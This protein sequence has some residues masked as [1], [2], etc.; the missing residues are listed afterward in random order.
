[1]CSL[2]TFL[3]TSFKSGSFCW[4]VSPKLL[5]NII[6]KSYIRSVVS[7]FLHIHYG[8]LPE[9]VLCL[10]SSYTEDRMEEELTEPLQYA[11]QLPVAQIIHQVCFPLDPCER[12]KI[13]FC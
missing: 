13:C 4:V 5:I 1:M 9:C 3:V 6:S 11:E 8:H 12:N 2:N 7:T 10:L